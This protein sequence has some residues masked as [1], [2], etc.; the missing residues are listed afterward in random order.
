M[1]GSFTEQ[2]HPTAS[3]D[4]CQI[5]RS[6][7]HGS[8]IPLP[9]SLKI[10]GCTLDK[11]GLAITGHKKENRKVIF[12][13]TGKSLGYLVSGSWLPKQYQG[14]VNGTDESTKYIFSKLNTTSNM[15]Y[16]QDNDDLCWER[17]ISPEGSLLS[18]LLQA[19]L[20]ARILQMSREMGLLTDYM[21]CRDKAKAGK[22][23]FNI[24]NHFILK[25]GDKLMVPTLPPNSSGYKSENQ[26]NNNKPEKRNFS[27]SWAVSSLLTFGK[28]WV[29]DP[30]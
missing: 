11:P 28:N 7:K 26:C 13:L 2:L 15:S 27:L 8:E 10:T 18:F 21:H 23:S 1:Q 12:A 4:D 19:A 24:R 25:A 6:L 29:E 14:S 17:I 22:T 30:R 3:C 9:S 16:Q 20:W 5:F